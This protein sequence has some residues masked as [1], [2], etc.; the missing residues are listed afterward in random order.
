MPE[1]PLLLKNYTP[2]DL[3]HVPGLSKAVDL[4]FTYIDAQPAKMQHA[5]AKFSR[6]RMLNIHAH[7]GRRKKSEK[8]PKPG[9]SDLRG[10]ARKRS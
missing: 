10:G 4:A 6:L 1:H 8:N 9:A 3:K 2:F 7:I 5:K